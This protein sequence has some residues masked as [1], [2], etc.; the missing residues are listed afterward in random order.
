MRTYLANIDWNNL[1]KNKTTTECWT[2]LKD[3]IEGITARF[4][5]LR[6]ERYHP[7]TNIYISFTKHVKDFR[8]ISA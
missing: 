2:C 3:E 7:S 5:L 4:V 6:T 1:L 8:L